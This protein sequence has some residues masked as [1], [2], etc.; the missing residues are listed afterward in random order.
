MWKHVRMILIMMVVVCL[1]GCILLEQPSNSFVEYY[2]RFRELIQLL[3][4]SGGPHAAAR[5]WLRTIFSLASSLCRSDCLMGKVCYIQAISSP[6][7]NAYC[8]WRLSLVWLMSQGTCCTYMG[9]RCIAQCGTCS[10]TTVRHPSAIW[11]LPT[12]QPL[13]AWTAAP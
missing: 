7:V 9:L 10:T 11:R 5:C 6:L 4:A 3:Q 12:V 2:P 13:E 8:R 1:N